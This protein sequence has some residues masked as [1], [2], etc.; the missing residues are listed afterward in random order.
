MYAAG[1]DHPLKAPCARI[2]VLAASHRSSFVTDAEVLQEILHRYLSLNRGEQGRTLVMDFAQL[3][4][5]RIEPV[6]GED[7]VSAAKT[8]LSQRGMSARDLVHLAVMVRL[9][10]SR[11]VSA[12][13][14]FDQIAEVERIRPES[15]ESWAMEL[16]EV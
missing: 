1:A 5:G 3:M 9:D 4:Q 2:I 7:I 14:G 8:S 12:D 11:I 13:T 10:L 15:V 6:L 16:E